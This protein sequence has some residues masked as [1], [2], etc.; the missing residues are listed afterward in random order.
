MPLVSL[1]T[2]PT[3]NDR[4]VTL[5]LRDIERGVNLLDARVQA[6]ELKV[7]SLATAADLQSLTQR[8]S[9]LESLVATLQQQVNG[10]LHP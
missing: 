6:V 5:G 4:S 10:I 8:V 9:A 2:I 3:S 1:G 7:P